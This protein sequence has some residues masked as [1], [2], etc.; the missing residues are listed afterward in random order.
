MLGW[1]LWKK[2][3]SGVQVR[4]ITSP[5][6]PMQGLVGRYW[7]LGEDPNLLFTLAAFFP[8]LPQCPL[9]S[10]ES[11]LHPLEAFLT[12][13]S[14]PRRRDMHPGCKPGTPR[15][16]QDRR[17]SCREDTGLQRRTPTSYSTLCLFSLGC[18]NNPLKAWWPVPVAQ[19]PWAA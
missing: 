10:L 13:W 6:S 8:G 16:P 17:R 9:E 11:S 5:P 2:H 1:P 3:T 19:G 4:D 18:L 7:P 15:F 12:L 14:G